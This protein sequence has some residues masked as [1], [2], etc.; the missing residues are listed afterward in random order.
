MKN[1]RVYGLENIEIIWISESSE[2]DAINPKRLEFEIARSIGNFIRGNV[3]PVV[4]I[5]GFELLMLQNGYENVM[6]FIKKANDLAS[7]NS[8]TIIVPLNPSAIKR[9]DIPLLTKEF[10]KVED[11]IEV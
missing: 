9:E 1:K 3:D 8:A 11:L 10:D 7:V 2:K 4:V 5:D 6:K